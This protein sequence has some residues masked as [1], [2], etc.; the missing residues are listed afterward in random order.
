MALPIAMKQG[1]VRRILLAAAIGLL[2]TLACGTEMADKSD[3]PRYA[4]A[5]VN[6]AVE[7]YER[8][9][10]DKTLAYYNSQASQDGEWYV[11]V[12][13]DTGEII[14]RFD[15]KFV[16]QNFNRELRED[17]NGYAYGPEMLTATESGKWVSY[18]FENPGANNALTPKHT[19]TVRRDDLFFGA[20][21]YEGIK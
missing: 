1:A 10:R 14:A 5:L 2:L 6:E 12:Y 15:R 19:W 21:W 9:G 3:P 18:V 20:G 4:Q 7:R 8:D 16:G 11:F 13:D 17:S